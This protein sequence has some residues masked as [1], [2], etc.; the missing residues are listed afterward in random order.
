MTDLLIT[1]DLM[2]TFLD[3]L[4]QKTIDGKLKWK[5]PGLYDDK[6]VDDVPAYFTGLRKKARKRASTAARQTEDELDDE[7]AGN[8]QPA[9]PCTPYYI[10]FSGRTLSVTRPAAG[11]RP[12]TVLVFRTRAEG[13]DGLRCVLINLSFTPD[14]SDGAVRAGQIQQYNLKVQMLCAAIDSY[15]NGVQVLE[16]QV[17]ED[18]N[19]KAG[20]AAMGA[21]GEL[22]K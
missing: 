14:G 20:E 10:K 13:D 18:V 22:L 5:V 16:D 2:G 9:E 7:C 11:D 4:I 12:N 1:P 3:G 8:I 19:I 21:L 6:P 17:A 15:R